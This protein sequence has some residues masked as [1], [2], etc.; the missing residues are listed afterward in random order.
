MLIDRIDRFLEHRFVVEI[1]RLAGDHAK[2]KPDNSKHSNENSQKLLHVFTPHELL[3]IVY[4]PYFHGESTKRQ[5]Y[6]RIDVP[7]AGRP[8]TRAVSGTMI[9]T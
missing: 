8:L 3:S 1:N 7:N 4:L 5:E 9:E 6:V 2:R